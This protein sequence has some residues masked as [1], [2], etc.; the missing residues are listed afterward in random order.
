[1]IK[2]LNHLVQYF[3]INNSILNLVGNFFMIA[4]NTYFFDYI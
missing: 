2:I 3:L 4:R 1:M